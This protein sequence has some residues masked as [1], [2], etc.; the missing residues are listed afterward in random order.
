IY[1]SKENRLNHSEYEIIMLRTDIIEERKEAEI[2]I[3]Q[4][5]NKII[6]THKQSSS[7]YTLLNSK[8]YKSINGRGNITLLNKIKSFKINKNDNGNIQIDL[9]IIKGRITIRETIFI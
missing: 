7:E 9:E 1:G 4:V 5:H 8:I 2:K 3:N 6:F